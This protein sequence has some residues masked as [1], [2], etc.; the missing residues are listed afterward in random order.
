MSIPLFLRGFLAVL[1]VFALTTYIA[2]QSLWTTLVQTLICAVLIQFG[3]FVA[4]LFMIWRSGT[5]PGGDDADENAEGV[6]DE[7]PAGTEIARLPTASR[8]RQS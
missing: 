4:V 3:Y 1:A 8:S 5:R 2:T 6:G 7:E